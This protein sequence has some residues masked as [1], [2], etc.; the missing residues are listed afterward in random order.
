MTARATIY[1]RRNG[2]PGAMCDGTMDTGHHIV[3]DRLGRFTVYSVHDMKEDVVIAAN[4]TQAQAEEAIAKD[5][6]SAN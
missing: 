3:V 4:T 2:A 6:R 5:W 1:F